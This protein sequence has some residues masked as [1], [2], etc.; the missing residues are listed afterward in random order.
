MTPPPTMRWRLGRIEIVLPRGWTTADLEDWME[1]DAAL[2]RADSE[3][4]E[5]LHAEGDA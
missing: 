1:Q 3:A 2:Y 5:D 4:W